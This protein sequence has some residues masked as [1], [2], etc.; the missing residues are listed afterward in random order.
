MLL[1]ILRLLKQ[2]WCIFEFALFSLFL[3]ALSWAPRKLTDP[4]YHRLFLL[5]CRSFVYALNIDLRKHEKHALPLPDHYILISNHP[6]A[7]EDI[8]VPAL[9]DVYP[10]AKWGVKYWFIVGRISEA[11]GTIYVKRTDKDSRRAAGEQLKAILHQG[12]NISLFP[13]GGC[14]GKR[15][16]ERFEFGAFKLSMETGVPI[17]PVFLHYEMQ[18]QFEWRD[19]QTLL[20]KL[21]HFMTCQNNR[22]N[23]YVYDPIYPEKFNNKE[24]YSE[25]VHQLYLEWQKRYL[26]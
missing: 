23:Y 1:F 5:W 6:S 16:Y 7:F 2:L 12:K 13:E 22:A 19:P 10:L 24:E 3:Y 20:D 4:F 9:F 11:A 26:D 18:E 21:W 14:K 25:Y 17:V 15:I 8:G